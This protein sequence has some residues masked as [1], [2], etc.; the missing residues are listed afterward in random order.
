MTSRDLILHI[1]TD[2]AARARRSMQLR[3][4]SREILES[5]DS[6]A[7]SDL[8]AQHRAALTIVDAPVDE[9]GWPN[10]DVSLTGG[11][12]GS[13]L[14][15]ISDD[16][17]ARAR[18]L[19]LGADAALA[20]SAPPEEFRA[21]VA[22]LLRLGNRHAA[23]RDRDQEMVVRENTRLFREV[24]SAN[25]IKDEFIATLSHELRNP[26]AA[27]RYAL[28]LIQRES[29]GEAVGQAVQVIH[30]QVDHLSQMVDHLL[31]VSRI[32]RGTLLLR[33]ERV[34][35]RG[36]LAAA[37]EAASG[38]LVRGHHHLTLVMPER[39]V[40]LNA[41][42]VR[43]T[44][45][46]THL[47]DNAAAFTP[48]GGDIALE[49]SANEAE[50]TIRV[51]DN[52]AG[53]P[54]ESLGEIFD[55][56]RQLHRDD[57]RQGGLGIGLALSKRLVE[58]HGGSI[59]A[60]SRGPG[61]G[62]EFAVRLPVSTTDAPSAAAAPSRPHSERRLKVLIVDDNVDLVEMLSATVEALGH[63]V[64][65][66]FDGAMAV[67]RALAYRPDVILLDL[68][69][70][71]ISGIDVARRLRSRSETAGTKLVAFTGWGQ[72]DDRAQ[73]QAAGFDYH[74]TKPADLETLTAVLSTLAGS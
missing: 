5:D 2:H 6:R 72:A 38:A 56:F 13:V 3:D 7:V 23:S 50:A 36:L 16:G 15:Y 10:P 49:G 61:L 52:G 45:V 28:P 65:K 22:S 25:Q 32:L 42:P 12:S 62:S 17:A 8:M 39:P 54:A 57:T 47:L 20:R 19:E 29:L 68:G 14:L 69:L 27:I 35:L 26:L 51:R 24:Q 46:V 64:E 18:A 40:W 33:R 60:S 41:D 4:A 43:I 31:D 9:V 37:A 70:P 30:R 58:L 11:L 55:F 67:E 48:R 74:L 73:T 34:E 53:I 21:T 59:H 1:D 44:Q 63:S 66:A 71:L